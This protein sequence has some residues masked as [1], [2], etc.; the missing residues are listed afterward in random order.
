MEQYRTRSVL[1]LT[2]LASFMAVP[3]TAEALAPVP[4]PAREVV[5]T[6]SSSPNGEGRYRYCLCLIEGA[7]RSELDLLVRGDKMAALEISNPAIRQIIQS[8]TDRVKELERYKASGAIG[9][10]NK[11]LV[12]IR[13]LNDLP[14]QERAAVQKLVREENADRERMFKKIAVATDLSQ[15]ARIQEIY[16][17]TLR[18]NARRGDWLQMPDGQWH[19]KR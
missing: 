7:E 2:A 14:L 5:A 19:Q 18:A 17:K 6:C 1:T 11:A 4:A 10:T 13:D 8:R 16:A 15:L 9:E 3:S 12:E